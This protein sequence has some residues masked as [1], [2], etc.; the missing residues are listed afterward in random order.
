MRSLNFI[1][2]PKKQY[3]RI[4]SALAH[5]YK[6]AKH[7]HYNDTIKIYRCSIYLVFAC[8][9][10]SNFKCSIFPDFANIIFALEKNDLANMRYKEN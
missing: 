6:Y 2:V 10:V 5:A 3:F 7:L 4:F 9:F 1:I 8:I